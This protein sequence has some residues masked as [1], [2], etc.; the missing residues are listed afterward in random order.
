M[1]PK[2]IVLSLTTL[3]L[4]LLGGCGRLVT[5]APAPVLTARNKAFNYTVVVTKSETNKNTYEIQMAAETASLRQLLS[6]SKI[7]H[8]IVR[9]GAQDVVVALD[10]VLATASKKWLLYV[11]GKKKLFITLDD[12]NVAPMEQVEWRYE[13]PTKP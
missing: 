12:V 5:S 10:G 7:K 8:E 13:E 1:Y 6:E 2:F 11:A 9:K 3:V 4:V